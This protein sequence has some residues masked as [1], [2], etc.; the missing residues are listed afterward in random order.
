MSERLSTVGVELARG[1][2]RCTSCFESLGLERAGIALPQPFSVGKHYKSGGI[3]V[4][5][6]NP[7]AAMDGGYKEARKHA[8]DRFAE[9]EDG[10]LV[11]Y[12]EALASDA[13]NFWNPRYLA[14]IRALGLHI[15]EL[16]VGNVALCATANNHYPKRM[17]ANCWSRHTQRFLE[18]FAP[19]TLILMGS[20]GV[21]GDFLNAIQKAIPDLRIER[22]AHYA[23]REGHAHEEA[24]CERIR[25]FLARG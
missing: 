17:L 10:A 22:I 12:W 1:A 6:I 4:V 5:G 7:G 19:G 25:K 9:G 14:R 8:L 23:H 2:V 3:A 11:S 15:E 16:L 21:M 20:T 18:T 24:E 13:Q